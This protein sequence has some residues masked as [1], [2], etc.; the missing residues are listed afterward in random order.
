MLATYHGHAEL[1][2]I[3]LAH[4]ADPNRLNDRGQS[5]LAGALF[6]GEDEVVEVLL[7]H[8]GATGMVTGYADVDIGH[9]SAWDCMTLFRK[10]EAWHAKFEQQRSKIVAARGGLGGGGEVW[11]EG[12]GGGGGGEGGGKGEKGVGGVKEGFEM[13]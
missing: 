10:E 13:V 4:G 1:A 2:R 7:Q 6:K 9:P 5:P 8:C 3:L 12:E 11:R